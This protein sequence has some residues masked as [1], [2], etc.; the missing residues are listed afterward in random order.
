MSSDEYSANEEVRADM[1]R[2][3]IAAVFAARTCLTMVLSG[4]ASAGPGRHQ[5]DPVA[6]ATAL[7][8][9]LTL[10]EKITEMHG[11]QDAT[12]NRFVPGIARLGIPPLV[13]TNGPAGVGP[14]DPQTPAPA[15]PP[16]APEGPAPP[17]G[18]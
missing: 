9:Q 1:R 8:A 17:P 3:R 4:T 16:P 10:A 14:G 6:R 7:V 12:H 15:T 18:S 11:I 5:Q 13:I 2:R